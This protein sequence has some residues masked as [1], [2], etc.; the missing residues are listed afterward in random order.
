MI[1]RRNF[2]G[3]AALAAAQ[4]TGCAPL[5]IAQGSVPGAATLRPRRLRAGDTVGLVSPGS[6]IAE[7][8]TVQLA[9]EAFEA[10]GLRV[11]LGRFARERRGYFAGRDEDRAADLNAMFADDGV[12]AVFA[13]R[14][15]WG[16]ARILPMVNFDVIRSNPK[17]LLGYSD[18]TA[19]L[20]AV[21]ARTGLVTFHGPMGVSSWT[22][23]P[24]DHFRRLLFDAEA[25]E[26][27]NPVGTGGD[28]V[29]RD[30]R[31][32]TINPGV[33]R[34]RLVGGNLAV[35]SGV[36]GSAYLPDWSGAILFLEDVD[37]GIHRIDRMLTQLRLA[38]ILERLNGVVFGKC[39]NC[40]PV[41]SDSTGPGQG[42]GSLTLTE[43]L[44]DHLSPLRVPAWSGA[45]IGHITDQWT[46]PVGAEVEIDATRGTIR[47]LEPAVR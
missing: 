38:G 14:G 22:A 13:L 36:V 40:L 11:R 16:T 25:M 4:L 2:L 7:P 37:E 32:Q 33:A 44:N 15:G 35:I 24:L 27:S 31:V 6:P 30:H 41:Y 28:L 10:M 39:T 8:L 34:G 17:I 3:V 9:R 19:L 5:A 29:Q 20:N 21:N 18:I 43:V 47:M 12:D 1:N 42:Y 45:M 23:Y 26:F 46:L